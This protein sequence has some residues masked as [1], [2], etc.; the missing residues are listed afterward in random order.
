[1]SVR[2]FEEINEMLIESSF[3]C[4]DSEVMSSLGENGYPDEN[5][6][7]N[8]QSELLKAINKN[9]E[10]RLKTVRS[11]FL[12]FE[13][14]VS[15]NASDISENM[16]DEAMISD[17]ALV[18]SGNHNVPEG[19]MIAFREQSQSS[20]FDRNDIQKIWKDLYELELIKREDKE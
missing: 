18:M 19:I 5:T 10:K 11:D 16:S 15:N 14:K 12:S 7:C 4:A 1:M 20:K 3:E 8:V 17:I 13:S 2:L 6:V 9:R